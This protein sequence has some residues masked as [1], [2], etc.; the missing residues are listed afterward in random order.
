MLPARVRVFFTRH[1]SLPKKLMG[2]FQY[3]MAMAWQSVDDPEKVVPSFL[4][5]TPGFAL[6][7]E[8]Q[9][10]SSEAIFDKLTM[11]VFEGLAFALR[12]CCITAVA[13]VGIAMEVGSNPPPGMRP[14]SALF[15]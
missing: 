15:Q 8:R 11:S 2:T 1:V 6:V 3:R 4:R 14:I 13:I 7:P 10:I 12:D 9:P 5:D